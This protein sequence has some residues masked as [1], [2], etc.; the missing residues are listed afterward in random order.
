MNNYGK[1]NFVIAKSAIPIKLI[2]Q[3]HKHLKMNLSLNLKRS[4]KIKSIK[5]Y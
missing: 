2:K 5:N 3:A 4:T 1:K